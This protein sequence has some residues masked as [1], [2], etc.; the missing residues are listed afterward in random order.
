MNCQLN[1]K[2]QQT[3]KLRIKLLAQVSH[4]GLFRSDLQAVGLGVTTFR[5][6]IC[7]VNS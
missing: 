1:F 5:D 3:L 4:V 7:Y 2:I 6:V